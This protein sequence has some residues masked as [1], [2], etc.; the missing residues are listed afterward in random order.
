MSEELSLSEAL[1]RAREGRG[2]S[3]DQVQQRT[4]ISVRILQALEEGDLEAVEPVYMR[5]GAVHYGTYLGLEGEA[6]A[7]GLA[8]LRSRERVPARTPPP[9]GGPVLGDGPIKV[10]AG[11]AI[12]AFAAVLYLMTGG[13][14]DPAPP[15]LPVADELPVSGD[16]SGWEEPSA[17]G[18]PEPVDFGAAPRAEPGDP[19]EPVESGAGS[20][21]APPSPLEGTSPAGTEAALAGDAASPGRLVLEGEALDTVWVQVSWDETDS[22]METIPAGERRTWTAERHFLVHAGRSGNIRFRFQG[23]LLGGGRLGDPDRTLRFRVSGDGYRLLGP[24]FQ[25]IAPLTGFQPER[26][27]SS[28]P[29]AR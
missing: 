15:P 2:E 9:R 14:A 7:Q 17:A 24:D 10:A 22:A 26:T 11:L 12:A 3:L 8:G 23:Q 27:E 5:M 13:E 28:Q 6:L 21:L 29:E 16:R 25:P 4:G 20:E 19:S 1:R 18:S